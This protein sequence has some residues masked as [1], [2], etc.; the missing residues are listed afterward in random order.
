VETTG[1]AVV[2]AIGHLIRRHY[3]RS[4]DE[5]LRPRNFK[6]ISLHLVL[7]AKH[8]LMV[9]ELISLLGCDPRY[10]ERTEASTEMFARLFVAFWDR[11]Y[12]VTFQEREGAEGPA[13]AL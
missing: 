5:S 13:E 3:K 7:E 4:G 6:Y 9:D 12:S 1:F 8:P 2:E 10:T 11:M